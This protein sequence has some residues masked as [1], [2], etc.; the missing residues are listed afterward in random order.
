[1]IKAANSHLRYYL[2]QAANSVKHH[3]PEFSAFYTKKYRE[4][5]KHQ[6]KRAL[7]LTARKLVR[8]IFSLEKNK[9]LYQPRELYR[10]RKEKAQ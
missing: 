5:P 3:E 2:I 10:S 6:H 8:L 1:M 7:V 9:S 4:V